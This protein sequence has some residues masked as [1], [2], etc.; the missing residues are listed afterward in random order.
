[1]SKCKNL[2]TSIDNMIFNEMVEVYG[3]FLK[4]CITVGP[5]SFYG[6]TG[7][8]VQVTN[9]TSREGI[10]GVLKENS[11]LTF[12]LRVFPSEFASQLRM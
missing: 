1:M 12:V 10:M 11:G 2:I 9:D 6:T 3:D 5:S 8:R 7:E 4:M